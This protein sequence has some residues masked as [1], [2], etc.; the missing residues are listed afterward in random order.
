MFKL[1]KRLEQDTIFI[2]NLNLSKLLLMNNSNFPWL[3]LVPMRENLIELIDL[4][5]TD[6]QQL[7]SE[8][9]SLSRFLKKTDPKGKINIG[10]LGNI[11]NQLHIHIVIRNKNDLAWPNSI[12]GFDNHSP[13]SKEQSLKLLE[14][15]SNFLN[16]EDNIPNE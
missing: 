1:D 10:T 6:Q 7:L 9:S 2:K 12:W 3:I 14:E 13:Y 11:V 15:I 8:I 16:E 4:S 5:K